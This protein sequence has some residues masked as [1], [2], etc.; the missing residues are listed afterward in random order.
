MTCPKCSG[1]TI[2]VGTEH[3]AGCTTRY[4]R[5][6]ICDHK[7]V[8]VEVWKQKTQT[9]TPYMESESKKTLEKPVQPDTPQS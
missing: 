6:I 3:W 1:K 2:V 8:S 5:C 7:A 4:R 9:L